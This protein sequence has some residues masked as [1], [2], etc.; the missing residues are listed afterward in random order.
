M[1]KL[2][3]LALFVAL[4]IAQNFTSCS[5]KTNTHELVKEPPKLLASTKNGKKYI[6]QSKTDLTSH[7]YIAVLQG[8]PYEM[9]YAYGTLFKN[10]IK[11]VLTAVEG[12]YEIASTWVNDLPAWMRNLTDHPKKTAWL[13]TLFEQ[14]ATSRYTPQRYFDEMKGIAD[15]SGIDYD[16]LVRLN[17]FPELIRASCSIIGVWGPASKTGDLLQVRA[18][19]WVAAAPINQYPTVTIYHS[20]EPG[21]NPHANIGWAGLVGSLAGYSTKVGVAEKVWLPF[22]DSLTT[23]F[24]EPWMYVLRDVLQFANNLGD[25]INMIQNAKKTYQ[26]YVGVG[27]K[28]D[29]ELR[30]FQYS[31]A[32]TEVYSDKNWSKPFSTNHPQMNGVMYWDKSVAQNDGCISQ[33]LQNYYGNIDW[34]I[35]ANYV[36]PLHKTGDTLLAVYDFGAN[37]VYV[38][39]ANYQTNTP[40]YSR[41]RI[42]LNMTQL[43]SISVSDAAEEISI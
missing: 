10:E 14:I 42:Y 20:T 24:G 30:G 22:N 38:S 39:F 34:N 40:A 5:G 21:S 28:S 35:L 15:A 16:R 33:V 19:D 9:G 17:L 4:S 37:V 29:N 36:S 6:I 12:F 43:F 26:I 25:A 2:I 41:P 8:T 18:L 7:V 32:K 27:S 3:I 23:I 1:N 31:Y 11:F 13:G